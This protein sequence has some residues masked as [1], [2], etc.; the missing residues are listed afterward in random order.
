MSEQFQREKTQKQMKKMNEE[1]RNM[2]T[3]LQQANNNLA[4]VTSSLLA[5]HLIIRDL[6]RFVNQNVPLTDRFDTNGASLPPIRPPPNLTY[7][8]ES[9]TN[10]PYRDRRYNPVNEYPTS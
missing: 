10:L 5:S 7:S 9:F 8:N 3:A 1:L 2:R 6:N 4:D